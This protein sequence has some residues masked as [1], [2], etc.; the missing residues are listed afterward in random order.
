MAKTLTG[1]G[2]TGMS[3]PK[4]KSVGGIR[5]PFTSSIVSKG[6]KMGGKR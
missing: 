6:G 5:T 2:A 4:S 3:G 1:K